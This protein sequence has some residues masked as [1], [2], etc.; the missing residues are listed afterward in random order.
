MERGSCQGKKLLSTRSQQSLQIRVT[1]YER[2][3]GLPA[4]QGG[5]EKTKL[6]E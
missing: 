5:K 3:I 4:F 6:K 1:T 2:F